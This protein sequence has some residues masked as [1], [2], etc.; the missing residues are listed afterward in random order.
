MPV[1]GTDDRVLVGNE[2]HDDAGVYRISDDVALVQTVDFFTPVVDDPE[3]FGRIAAANS[4]SDVYAMGGIP[5]TAL[6]LLAVPE[7]VLPPATLGAMLRG[8]QAMITAAG[9]V[10][11]GGHSIDDPEP[12][13]GYAVTGTVHPDHVW[14]N[15]TA[16]EGDLL[17]L[18]KPVGTGVVIK[19]IKDAVAEPAETEA[20]IAWMERLNRGARDLIVDTIRDPSACTDVTGFGLLGHALEM[21]LGSGLTLA[22]RAE[23]VPLVEGSERQARADRFPAG[24]RD[25]LRYVEPY[26]LVERPVPDWRLGLLADAVTSGGLLF[27]VP[28]GRAPELEAEAA[29]R[30]QPLF[31]IG[32]V[33]RGKKPL[34]VR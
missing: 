23:A 3:H 16:R 33:E 19:A 17:Y 20:V 21:A 27:T 22:I 4:L 32:R 8:G 9:A 15:S 11:I 25:N 10:L 30:G 34:V 28:E 13:M 29:R 6:N 26:L 14:R 31:R 24:S 2:T 7:G 5:L 1:L 12:K 18:T